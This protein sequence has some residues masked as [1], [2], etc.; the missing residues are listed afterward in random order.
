MNVRKIVSEQWPV[1]LVASGAAIQVYI[2]YHAS[3]MQLVLFVLCLC[4]TS[5]AIHMRNIYLGLGTF[6]V[7]ELVILSFVTIRTFSQELERIALA[8]VT[9][10]LPSVILLNRVVQLHSLTKSI[11]LKQAVSP[12]AIGA[13]IFI[14]AG[15][16]LFFYV[17]FT[18]PFLVP[19]MLGPE[20]LG[21]NL[22]L[23]ATA[24]FIFVAPMLEI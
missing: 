12:S 4:M 19:Y 2:D 22:L 21:V 24:T 14:I 3:L 9:I 6:V 23:L 16:V 17:L 8:S 15:T 1:A 5:A 13:V 20:A 10:L 11:N 18:L 7:T